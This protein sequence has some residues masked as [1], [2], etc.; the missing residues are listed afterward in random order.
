MTEKQQA[1]RDWWLGVGHMVSHGLAEGAIK[2]QRVHLSIADET[3]NILARNPVTGPVSE[4]VRSVHHG[5]SRLCYGTVSLV[6]DGLAR[7]SQQALP[8]D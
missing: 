2:A 3:F 8:K 6:S 4:Q 1:N 7:L 5:V